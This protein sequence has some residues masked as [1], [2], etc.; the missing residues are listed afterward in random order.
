MSNAIIPEA[1]NEQVFHLYFSISTVIG[2]GGVYRYY[3]LV[4]QSCI[5]GIRSL[6]SG[7]LELTIFQWKNETH[8]WLLRYDCVFPS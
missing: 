7:A 1:T 8:M 4:I 5:R 2:D 6:V 3:N